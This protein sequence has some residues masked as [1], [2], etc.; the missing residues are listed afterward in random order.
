MK[1]FVTIFTLC[2]FTLLL[3]SLAYGQYE[4]TLANG[5]TKELGITTHNGSPYPSVVTQEVSAG[6]DFDS[7][8]NLEF[9][10]LA[11][12]SNPQGGTEYPTGASLWLYE[13]STSGYELVWSWWDTTLY[14]G[15]A[16][17]PTHAVGD[18][19]GDNNPELLL[20]IPYGS[21]NPPD[22]SNPN[23]CYVWEADASG[24]PAWDGTT[25]PEPTAT[26]NFG[27]SVG[28]NTRPSCMAVDDIDG[29]GQQEVAMG[30]RAFSDAAANDAMMIF[31]LNGQFFGSLTQW[32]I[33]MLDTL[34]NVG[35]TYSAAITDLDNDGNKE[36]FFSTDYGSIFEAAGTNT[37]T[38][39][40]EKDF[41][42]KYDIWTVHGITTWDMDGDG[43]LELIVGKTNGSVVIIDGIT[44]LATADSNN[45]HIVD[46]LA[47]SGC[48][49]IAAGDF[50]NDGNAD[51]MM[52]GNYGSSVWWMEYKGAGAITDSAS[53]TKQMVYQADTSGSIRTYSLAFGGAYANGGTTA[54]LDKDG[55]PE[56][57]VGHEDGDSTATHYVVVL[58]YDKSVAIEFN[59]G[60]PVL[61]TYSLYQNYPNPF[62]PNTT[63][64]YSIPEANI[65]NLS[66]YNIRGELIK[67]LVN[68]YQLPSEYTSIWDGTNDYG[69]KVASGTYIYKL[70][71]GGVTLSKTMTF[72]K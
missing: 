50:D 23:R 32:T 55:H 2:A 19:D 41:Q 57:V 8:G 44:D 28:T 56:V 15:G 17:F 13:A 25:P 7:D 72:V 14:T 3:M 63:I 37:Y 20:G 4:E 1:R 71:T 18:L 31:S 53:Y 66:V 69:E 21:G 47:P 42:S 10:V 27:V 59:P 29:D 52:A 51:I 49:G 9:L 43:D 58:D 30:F 35:S 36:A 24:L 11:D 45:V 39:Y 22:G 54:D 34:S 64:S 65:V 38:P 62:N 16:S 67:T 60:A 40:V 6:W 61:Q 12:H 68:N 26:W 33:E 70:T 48:R 46:V 5:W